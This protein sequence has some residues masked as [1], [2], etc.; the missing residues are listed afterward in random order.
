MKL[1]LFLFAH[2][3]F[4]M[5]PMAIGVISNFKCYY[6]SRNTFYK[7]FIVIPDGTGQNKLKP[8]KYSF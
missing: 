2:T 8:V 7:R 1:V 4:I 3:T 6:Y 5:Q